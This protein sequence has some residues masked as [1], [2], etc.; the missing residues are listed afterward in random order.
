[1][2]YITRIARFAAAHRLNNKLWNKKKNTAVYGKCCGDAPHGHNYELSVT[3]KGLPDAET[4]MLMNFGSL[5][6]VI[7][8]VV[9]V[10]DHRYLNELP[11]FKDKVPTSENM[12]VFVWDMLEKKLPRGLLHRITI[13]ETDNNET[14]YEKYD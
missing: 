7:E 8:R 2:V 5:K 4:G 9:R 6:K 10:F 3:L 14:S 12:C 1:M 11:I 13:K